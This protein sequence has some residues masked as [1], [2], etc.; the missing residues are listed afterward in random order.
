MSN[1]GNTA[2]PNRP[3]HTYDPHRA[4]PKGAYIATAGVVIFVVATFLAWIATDDKSF[5]GYEADTVI[6]FTAY[7]G[8]GFA[9][10]LLYAAKRATR[11]QHRGL[12]LASM[13]AGVAA[14][15]LALSYLIEVPGGAERKAG[16]DTEIGV[17]VGLVG[18]LIWAVGSFLLAMQP[19]GDI[20]HRE[21]GDHRTDHAT[22]TGN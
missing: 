21:D 3:A 2:Q 13:A 6:P 16:F 11:R 12:S 1:H 17:Y 4:D 10:A 8:L 14:T 19:E 15:G 20:E 9:A 7:L 18:A 22:N 5:S